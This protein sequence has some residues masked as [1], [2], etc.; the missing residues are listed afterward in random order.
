MPGLGQL[1]C[2]AIIRGLGFTVLSAGTAL[3][4]ILALVPRLELPG[5]ALAAIEGVSLVAYAVSI[6]DAFRLA[7]RTREDYV[8][9]DYNRWY[10]Y[11][12]LGFAVSGGHLF[13]MLFAREHLIQPFR[14][15][16]PSMYPTLW[17]GDQVMAA[18]NAYMLKDPAPGDIVVFHNPDDRSQLFTKR[19]VAVAGDSVE[20]RSGHVYVNGTELERRSVPPP[21][22][23]P[24]D[25]KEGAYFDELNRGA[26][27]RIYV[28]GTDRRLRN[29]APTVVP[30]HACFVMGDNRDESL[31]SRSFGAIPIIGIV[32]KVGYRYAPLDRLGSVQ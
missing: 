21:A 31:D 23:T 29:L 3:L 5:A 2:G 15:A 14:L 11:V 27:Y 13:A 18:R 20:I 24:T 28:S 16:A 25:I 22:S 9:K 26:K 8:L 19:V 32:G 17:K 12:L 1:Y 10:A 7:R 4:G 6:F 30:P